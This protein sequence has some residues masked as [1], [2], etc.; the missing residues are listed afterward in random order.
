[1]ACDE[2]AQTGEPDAVKKKTGDYMKGGA[3]IGE[4]KLKE[5]LHDMGHDMGHV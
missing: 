3:T 4:G 1:M 2:S 5:G